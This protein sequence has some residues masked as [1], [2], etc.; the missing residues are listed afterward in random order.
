M[1]LC[2]YGCTFERKPSGSLFPSG[3]RK[4]FAFGETP[5]MNMRKASIISF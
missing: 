5:S 2:E 1:F 3:E 4:I